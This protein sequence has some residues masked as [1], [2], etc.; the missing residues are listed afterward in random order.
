[1]DKIQENNFNV[2]PQQT[3]HKKQASYLDRNKPNFLW[4]VP[5]DNTKSYCYNES[6]F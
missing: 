2:S 4:L 3:L 6:K 5:T 1:M